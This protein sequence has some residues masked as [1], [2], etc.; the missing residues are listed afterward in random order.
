M[1]QRLLTSVVEWDCHLSLPRISHYLVTWNPAD[2][3]DQVDV[4]RAHLREHHS[5]WGTCSSMALACG[6]TG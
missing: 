3:R 1:Q 4:V 5:L 2:T 6:V